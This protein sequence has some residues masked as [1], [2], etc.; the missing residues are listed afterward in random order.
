MSRAAAHYEGEWHLPQL[1]VL[2]DTLLPAM[3]VP[4]VLQ[5][6]ALSSG[7]SANIMLPPPGEGDCTGVA[8]SA[9]IPAQHCLLEA[10]RDPWLCSTAPA[11]QTIHPVQDG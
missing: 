3:G 10:R 8:P 2:L 5:E 7:T 4:A 6:E 1:L 9:Y 11:S